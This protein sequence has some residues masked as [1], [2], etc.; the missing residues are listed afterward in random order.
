MKEKIMLKYKS[1]PNLEYTCKI[2]VSTTMCNSI[3]SSTRTAN[4]HKINYQ[5]VLN[6]W[7]DAHDSCSYMNYYKAFLNDEIS[8]K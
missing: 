1:S 3:Y 5:C 2:E 8:D 7:I 4:K 6:D